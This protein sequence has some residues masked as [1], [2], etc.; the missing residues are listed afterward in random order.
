MKIVRIISD[1]DRL[2]S[3]HNE[4]EAENEFELLFQK[5]N[6]IEYLRNFFNANKSDLGMLSVNE[7]VKKTLKDAE[8][9]ED[10]LI[11]VAESNIQLQTL[12]KPLSNNEYK[13][14]P[15]QESKVYGT[16][17]QSWLR[18][19]AIRINSDLF[20]V[21]GGAIKLTQTMEERDHTKDQLKRISK[22]RNYLKE[23]GFDES[24]LKILEI[25]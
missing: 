16:I 8:I 3:V 17:R 21:T 5:L 18:V 4:G 23:I 12:F 7:A 19:Y 6:D 2:L 22:A 15:Y 10:Q 1:V 24:N 11:D 25:E 20:V 13:L 9:L 14:K